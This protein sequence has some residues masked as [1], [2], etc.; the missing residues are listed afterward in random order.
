MTK[1]LD[2]TDTTFQDEVLSS[3]VPV[4]VDFWAEWCGPC[5]AMGPA[6]DQLAEAQAEKLKVVKHNIQDEPGIPS[7]FSVM[8]IPCFILFKEGKELARHS[9]MMNPDQL[10]SFIDPHI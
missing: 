2:V 8:A 7:Q 10:Q 1:A 6:V 4:L 3:S 9:G 5:K